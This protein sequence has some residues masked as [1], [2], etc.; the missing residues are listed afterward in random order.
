MWILSGIVTA[1]AMVAM[2]GLFGLSARDASAAKA[3]APVTSA[4]V[5]SDPNGQLP[6]DVA[7]L[8]AEVVAYQQQL[9]EAY[10]A[11]QQAY[12]EIQ[13]LSAGGSRGFRNRGGS[14]QL[15]QGGPG[16]D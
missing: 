5:A 16:D 8:Q 12:T 7:T 10:T 14:G 6:T 3:A 13:V 11:L 15:F 1:F 2:I 9:Q 4:A